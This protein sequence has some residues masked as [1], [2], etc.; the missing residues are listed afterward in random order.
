M[1]FALLYI[2][3]LA[4]IPIGYAVWFLLKDKLAWYQPLIASG[5]GLALAAI[6]HLCAFC[7]QGL[8]DN[9]LLHGMVQEAEF[10]PRWKEYYE[11][12]IYRTEFYTTTNDKGEIEFHT[13][14]VFDHWEPCTTWHSDTFYETD[15]FETVEISREQYQSILNEFGDKRSEHHPR[16]TGEHN[17]HQIGG[18][19]NVYY[20]VNKNQATYPVHITKSYTNRIIVNPTLF[21]FTHPE[22]FKPI[23][24]PEPSDRFNCQLTWGNCGIQNREVERLNAVLGPSK[25]VNLM[26]RSMGDKSSEE[27]HILRSDM[28]GGK[29]NDL[30]VCFGG[31]AERPTW[32]VVFGWS[33]SFLTM[34]NIETL[35]L[36]DGVN[37]TTLKNIG[38]EIKRTYQIKDWHKFDYLPLHISWLWLVLELFLILTA[39]T[40]IFMFLIP[41]LKKPYR[42]IGKTYN[43][44]NPYR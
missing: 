4:V 36:K 27:A 16:S 18:D 19:T 40:L 2:V 10:I 26:V 8:N 41:A 32:C 20:T 23:T 31:P 30:I 44:Y 43:R 29:R 42:Y 7:G 34:R 6:V 28:L 3:A 5:T 21:G 39:D 22:G 1:T 15:T 24:I 9:Q 11:E 12:A 13:R 35:V 14:Q 37:S 17:S 33:E 38:D 25:K